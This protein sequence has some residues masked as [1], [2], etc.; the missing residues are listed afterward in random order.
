MLIYKIGSISPQRISLFPS[1]QV[2][3]MKKKILKT[4]WYDY[5]PEPCFA[6]L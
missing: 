1:N 4:F 6:G 5:F 2:I 3:L